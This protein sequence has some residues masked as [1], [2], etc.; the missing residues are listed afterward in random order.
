MILINFLVT[1][2]LS[3][4]P[5][6]FAKPFAKPYVAGETIREVIEKIKVLNKKGFLA[7]VD[8]LGEHTKSKKEAKFITE[9]YCLLYDH[10]SEENLECSVSVKP[11]HIGLDISA[12]EVMSN[13]GK[14]LKKAEETNNFLRIDMESSNVTDKTIQIYE[15]FKKDSSSIGTV[16]QAY[17]FRTQTDLDKLSSSN[18]NIR[19]CKGIY[20]EPHKIAF[21]DKKEINKN[22]ILF[23]KKMARNNHFCAYATHDQNLIDKLVNW[24]EDEN[25]SKELFEFQCLYGVPMQGRLE[26]LIGDGFKVRIYVPFGSDWYDYSM[27]RLNENPKIINY[28]IGN[29]FKN[30]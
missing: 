28:V 26:K 15:H 20:D 10:I 22:Y 18:L 21:K 9:Q 12:I 24:I 16:L 8:I 14:I 13:I 2:S 30:D 19:I 27:R 11:T 25:I 17:L 1:R 23:A 6:W 29:L 5:K 3:L 7:T 4:L